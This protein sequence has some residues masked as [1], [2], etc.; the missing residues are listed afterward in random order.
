[1]AKK[2]NRSTKRKLPAKTNKAKTSTKKHKPNQPKLINVSSEKRHLKQPIKLPSIYRLFKT[3]LTTIWLNKKLFIGLTVVY[4]VLCLILVKG[5]ASSTDVSTLKTQLNMFFKGN[6]SSLLSGLSVFAVLI[7]SAGSGSSQTA[8]AYQFFLSIIVS[9]AIIWSLRQVLTG[10][11]V[12]IRDAYYQGMYPLIPFILILFVLVIQLVPIVIGA[13]LYEIATVNNIADNTLEK[14][15]FIVLLLLTIAWSFYM[16]CSSLFAL[17]IVTLPN[18]TPIKA[19]RS[20]NQLVKNRRL[21]V[22]RKIISLP[23]ILLIVSALIMLPIILLLTAT[24]EWVFF[25][26]TILVLL[27][28]HSYMYNLYRELLNE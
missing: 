11:K 6:L 9:L 22:F 21:L 25:V 5:F 15:I 14:L 23:V 13:V 12:R 26:L 27:V 20:A 8:G 10:H 4:G 17:Y 16:L 1:M 7:S 28:V 18:M 2:S 3:S 19:L 24:A